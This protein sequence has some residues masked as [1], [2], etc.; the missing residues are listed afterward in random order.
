MRCHRATPALG[1][2]SRRHSLVAVLRSPFRAARSGFPLLAV[3]ALATVALP[4]CAPRPAVRLPVL[5]VGDSVMEFA[6]PLL[7]A[8]GMT[9]DAQQSRQFKEAIPIVQ[10]DA[11]R[12]LLPSIVIVHLG[13]NGP[14]T[15]TICDALV[16]AV[17]HRRLILMNLSMHGQR[18]WE[19]TNDVVIAQCAARH[20]LQ[21]IDWKAA[22]NGQPWFAAD[23]IHLDAAGTRAYAT[24]VRRS[25]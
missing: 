12:G 14:I 1:R 25:L 3:L 16:A 21:L 10:S 5:A 24:I 8:Q 2:W 4:A 13:T 17:G 6:A 9:V 18:S 11:A 15:P 7:R 23:Q 22:S 19:Q 20:H